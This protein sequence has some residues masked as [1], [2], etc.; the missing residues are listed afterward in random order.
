MPQSG[1]T[2]VRKIL[3][4]RHGFKVICSKQ[5]LYKLSSMV[6]GLEEKE[7]YEPSLKNNTF[8]G[9][10]HRE[11]TGELGNAIEKLFGDSYLV[12]RAISA[13]TNHPDHLRDGNF[14]VDS[15]RKNQTKEFEGTVVEIISN[16]SINPGNEFDTYDRSKIDYQLNNNGTF[17]ELQRSVDA[18]M[19]YIRWIK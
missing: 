2:E 18:L 16:R 7:F 11:V 10:T 13:E 6:T 15:L 9:R 17:Y 8:I 14:V 4:S 5:I 3:E 19:E 1:K 12:N